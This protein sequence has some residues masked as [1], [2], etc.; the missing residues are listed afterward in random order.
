MLQEL[1][2]AGHADDTLV[3]YTSDNGVPFPS[4]RTNMYDPGL[5]EPL[6]I[7]SP[8]ARAR[9]NEAS[10]A[11]VSLLDIMPTVLDWFNI[12]FSQENN[13]ILPPDTAKSLLPI[14]EKGQSVILSN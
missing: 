8:D 13:D 14:L 10:H 11:M 5:R 12:P 6:I 7:A 9:K 1:Q 2:S 4:G 3:I